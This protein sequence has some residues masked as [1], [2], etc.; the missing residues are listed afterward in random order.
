[1]I[2]FDLKQKVEIDFQSDI[3][4]HPKCV[5]G[6]TLLFSRGGKKF[7]A[8]SAF[9]GRKDCDFYLEYGDKLSQKKMGIIKQKIKQLIEET[10]HKDTFDIIAKVLNGNDETITIRYC[11]TCD[12]VNCDIPEHNQYLLKKSDLLKP[13]RIL[14]PKS[15]D[16][17]EA[18]YFFSES[19]SKF[20]IDSI[21]RLKFTNV[22]CVGC[23]S[24]YE[25]LPKNLLNNS[26]LWDIDGRLSNFYDSNKFLWGNFFNGHFFNGDSSSTVFQN[27]LINCDK[28]L[29]IVD[30]PFG[31]KTELINFAINQ[32][33]EKL[34]RFNVCTV[35]AH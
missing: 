28:L 15:Q 12:K 13:S 9:R 10:I 17:K 31:A 6:P 35:S 33:K 22:L 20:V 26:I 34:G 14:K 5:H 3:S 18:Q 30:P 11:G 1:M 29:I 16:K 8:C 27:F 19:T 32:V 7:Y 25:N 4:K 2:D 23:P 21:Q 24:L